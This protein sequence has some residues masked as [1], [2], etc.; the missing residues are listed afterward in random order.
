VPDCHAGNPA[1]YFAMTHRTIAE[2]PVRWSFDLAQRHV[3]NA[4]SLYPHSQVIAV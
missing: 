4:R 2:A 3:P 1:R